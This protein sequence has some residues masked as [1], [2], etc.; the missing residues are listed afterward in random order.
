[1]QIFNQFN[2]RKLEKHEINVFKNLFNNCLF[3]IVFLV[4][5]AI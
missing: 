2:A 1:M 5:V 3:I 4:T